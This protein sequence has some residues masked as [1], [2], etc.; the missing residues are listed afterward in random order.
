M[1]RMNDAA[2]ATARR[3][4][5]SDLTDAQWELVEIALPKPKRT[6]RKR[7]IDLRE[8]VNAILYINRSGCQWDML[9]HDFPPRSSV[10]D[11]Y[12]A[13]R[14]DGTLVRLTHVLRDVVRECGTPERPASPS[15]AIID[16]QSVK[17]TER[18]GERGYDG[19]K[20]VSGRKRH[21]LVDTLGLLIAVVVT[22]ACVD[23]AAAA[24]ALFDE[25]DSGDYPRMQVVW[26]DG[27]YHN[28]T[29][30]AWKESRGD[31]PWRIEIVSRPPGTKG[32]VLLPRRWVVERTFAWLGRCRRLSK[33]YE[34][35]VESS[36]AMVRWSAVALCL[37]RLCP[38]STY[39]P[40]AYRLAA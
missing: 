34:R 35:T 17:T 21:I 22:A 5:P 8:V 30:Y 3:P 6:G 13:W 11:Y 29:L 23:D 14:T 40:F 19:G 27:K 32:F 7:S 4:Y 12:L 16:S 26:A 28:H 31:L 15:A 33:D 38:K 25:L 36:A 37:N 10:H 20:R 2:S 18:G 9:P 39:P 24:P 1:D